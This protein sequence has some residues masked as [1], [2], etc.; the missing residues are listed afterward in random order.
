MS[1]NTISLDRVEEEYLAFGSRLRSFFW[2][3]HCTKYIAYEPGKDCYSG[4]IEKQRGRFTFESH[5]LARLILDVRG[6]DI[7]EFGEDRGLHRWFSG[8]DESDESITKF[9]ANCLSLDRWIEEL[10]NLHLCQT[11]CQACNAMISPSR[12]PRSKRAEAMFHMFRE[13]RCP[14]GHLL[15][16][17]S[18]FH[19]CRIPSWKSPSVDRPLSW[20]EKYFQMK[21]KRDSPVDFFK[22]FL[23]PD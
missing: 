13:I 16:R 19:V 6:A 3:G 2:L 18:I 17:P 15:I 21:H 10:V 22:K 7:L 14:E 9:P 20:E 12:V 5:L 11:Y 8:A 4:L 23:D 1:G